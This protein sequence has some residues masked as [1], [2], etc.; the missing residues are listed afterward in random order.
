M[1]TGNAIKNAGNK[2]IK[3]QTTPPAEKEKFP[4]VNLS[5]QEFKDEQGIKSF[6]VVEGPNGRFMSS[7]G[8]SLGPVGKK[9]DL[10]EELQVIYS[11]KDDLYILCNRGNGDDYKVIATI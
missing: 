6:E 9:T 8:V 7:R 1:A 5:I 4:F 3:G 11:E 2:V 10:E